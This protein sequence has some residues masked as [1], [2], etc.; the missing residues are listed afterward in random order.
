MPGEMP[1]IRESFWLTREFNSALKSQTN[2][3]S[4][5]TEG[6]GL[7]ENELPGSLKSSEVCYFCPFKK[8]VDN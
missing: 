3:L 2:T 6:S 8:K 4:L 1:E 5:E 7:F